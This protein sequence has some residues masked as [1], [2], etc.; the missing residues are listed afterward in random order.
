MGKCRESKSGRYVTN[1]PLADVLRAV[2]PETAL[3]TT[4]ISDALGCSKPTALNK[5][6]QLAD[7]EIIT[8]NQQSPTYQWELNTTPPTKP[9][10]PH[11]DTVDGPAALLTET[12]ASIATDNISDQS[13]CNHPDLEAWLESRGVEPAH[14]R[15]TYASRVA[16]YRRFLQLTLYS[17]YQPSFDTLQ[18]LSPHSDI[19]QALIQAH[20]ITGDDRFELNPLDKLLAS[21]QSHSPRY[22]ALRHFLYLAS[23]PA[24]L[25]AT[26]YEQLTSKDAR[27]DLGQFATPKP[28][29]DAMAEWIHTTPSDTVLDPGIG[30]GQL[31]S[32]AL[33]CKLK[34]DTPNPLRKLVG[35]DI[36]P[37][38]TLMAD[39]SLK[40]IDGDGNPQIH[41]GN[42]LT[43]HVNELTP[44]ESNGFDAAIANPP[45]SR[46]K[47]DDNDI[48]NEL[49]DYLEARLGYEF[50]QDAPLYAYFIAH[51]ARF[52][53]P[54]SRFGVIVPANFMAAE[55]GTDLKQF[56]IDRFRIHGVLRLSENG[57]AFE[58]IRITPCILLLERNDKSVNT[59]VHFTQLDTFPP[60][61]SLTDLLPPTDDASHV[62]HSTSVAQH[63]LTAPEPWNKYFQ[64]F[65][66]DDHPALVPFEEITTS[67]KRG[68]ATGANDYFC[69]SNNTLEEYPIA[70][71][72]RTKILKSARDLDLTNIT[73]SDWE[74]WHA[75]EKPSWLLYC[76]RD[77]SDGPTALEREEISDKP[78]L[79]YLDAGLE[80]DVTDGCLVG[81]RDPWYR[82]EYREPAPVLGKYMNREGFHFMRND[83]GLRTLNNVHNI[84]PIDAFTSIDRDALLAYLNSHRIER[85]LAQSSP[86][87]NG[88]QKL[89]IKQLESAPVINPLALDE[90]HRCELAALF[91]ELCEARRQ[92][93]DDTEIL[94]AIEETI[95]A[96]IN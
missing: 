29:A 35:I 1:Y 67:I 61:V 34:R 31:A 84:T 77:T 51:A 30:A 71:A 44:Q 21:E 32:S 63:L 22:L 80:A 25:L 28:L 56:L 87:Y 66:I 27:R 82:V 91:E 69:L 83:A 40:L 14:D 78:T 60:D 45:F 88:L 8:H 68:I 33:Q 81:R 13:I 23:F 5:L 59:P 79:D 2:N 39:V 96:I 52:L 54:G 76:Y 93:K 94:T 75:N 7:W 9:D 24:Q 73:Q 95:E 70:E 90:D 17:L 55:F 85:H 46:H 49:N 89:G 19:T 62:R 42:F 41:N 57:D 36:D 6:N 16:V 3:T 65:S 58:D 37:I 64:P 86:E 15:M 10:T 26:T 92:D 48:K 50:K 4:Q 12:L 11:I 18:P 72:N 43:T 53:N 38:A 47:A 20:T 74:R